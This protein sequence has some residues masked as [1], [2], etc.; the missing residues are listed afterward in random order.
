MFIICLLAS[1]TV[2]ILVHEVVHIFQFSLDPRVEPIS[3]SLD[4]GKDSAA[5]VSYVYTT[6]NPQD[7]EEFRQQDIS[8]EFVA[9]TIGIITLILFL[10]ALKERHYFELK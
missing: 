7:I 6:N 8:R 1:I 10:Y 3:I 4:F 2:S 9:Y 5:H